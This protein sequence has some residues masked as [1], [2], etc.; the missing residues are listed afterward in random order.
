MK[1]LT[2]GAALFFLFLA[3]AQWSPAKAQFFKDILNNVKQTV[4]NRANGKANQSTNAVL[5]KVDSATK[6]S[7]GSDRKSVV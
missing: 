3:S 1:K 7:T 6:F 5:N 2:A 4:Q